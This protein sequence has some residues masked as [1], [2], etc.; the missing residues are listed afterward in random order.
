VDIRHSGGASGAGRIDGEGETAVGEVPKPIKL[1]RR[2]RGFEIGLDQSEGLQD[3]PMERPAYWSAGQNSLDHGAAA[4]REVEVVRGDHDARRAFRD[5]TG[6]GGKQWG[7]CGSVSRRQRIEERLHEGGGI[8]DGALGKGGGLQ[9]E[10][11]GGLEANANRHPP[12]IRQEDD[13]D[14][15]DERSEIAAEER[16]DPQ[17][18]VRG[19]PDRAGRS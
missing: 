17:A 4:A 7:L 8:I 15:G 16:V 6:E 1:H 11:G 18:Q 10:K 3:G 12:M 9:H 14:R 19:H 5:E 13:E 2:E